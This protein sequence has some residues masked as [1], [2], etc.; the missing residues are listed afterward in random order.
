MRL[1]VGF[2]AFLL[3]LPVFPAMVSAQLAPSPDAPPVSN[4]PAAPPDETPAASFKVNVS[5]VDLFFTVKDK[6][7]NLVHGSR[8]Q[9]ATDLQEL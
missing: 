8:R 4:A 2:A 5:L 3:G 6:S 9:D 1:G 7:G